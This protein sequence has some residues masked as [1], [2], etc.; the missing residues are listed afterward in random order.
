MVK[1]FLF[2]LRIVVLIVIMLGFANI[3]E[4]QEKGYPLDLDK[5]I[6]YKVYQKDSVIA[7]LGQPD[8]YSNYM[9]EF[10]LSEEYKF[11][12]STLI[13]TKNGE[14]SE[15]IL[16]DTRFAIFSRYISGG[17]RVGDSVNKFQQLGFGRIEI[18]DK[19][20]Y[21]FYDNPKCALPLIINH[22]SGIINRIL[23]Y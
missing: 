20:T 5:L 15:F 11:G 6:L 3:S 23:L 2:F 12:E 9:T 17:I 4:G 18:E 19:E 21:L 10:G 8:S 16:K 1:R 7:K 22:I 13:F 14:F